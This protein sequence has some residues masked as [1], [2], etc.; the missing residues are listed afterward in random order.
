MK[1]IQTIFIL[2][3][4]FWGMSSAA[5]FS[6]NEEKLA[7]YVEQASEWVA[8][9]NIDDKAKEHRLIDAIAVHRT[10]VKNWHDTHPASTVP[11][12][13]N[14]RTGDKLT[15]LDRQMIADS[16]IPKSV[17][18]N[19]MKA[20]RADL[21]EEQVEAILDKYT[22]G[23]VD[24]TMRGYRAIVP[25]LTAEEEAKILSYMKEA[26]EMAIDYKSMKQ[27]SAIF[28]I[29]KTKSE[30]YLIGNGRDWRQLYK[31]FVKSIQEQ[32]K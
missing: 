10:A 26:R 28:E 20:L 2:L 13:I 14:P 29:Y 11:E 6:Q 30:Q 19:L 7:Q 25:D 31:D 18:E 24:F 1:K 21:T 15:E 22:I 17:H 5:T 8:S 32:K 9:L 27:I 12:G 4:L 23:K 16:A 3:V